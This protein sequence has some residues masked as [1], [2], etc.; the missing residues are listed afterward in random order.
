MTRAQIKAA[1]E[2][3]TGSCKRFW[4]RISGHV[5]GNSFFL[6][7]TYTYLIIQ[8]ES[9]IHSSRQHNQVTLHTLNSNPPI[10]SVSDI[11]VATAFQN[12][13]NF[14]IAVEMLFK[15]YLELQLKERKVKMTKQEKIIWYMILW[16]NKGTSVNTLHALW[17]VLRSTCNREIMDGLSGHAVVPV[18]EKMA[19]ADWDDLTFCS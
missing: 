15:E 3:I 9:M 19:G 7:M 2:I 18:K 5:L 16:R 12:E 13:A 6:H 14:L 4:M 1:I 17:E 11:K 10:L 8:S